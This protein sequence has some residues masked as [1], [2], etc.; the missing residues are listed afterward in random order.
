ML[1]INTDVFL[2]NSL[3]VCDSD[4]WDVVVVT[5]GL[6]I[7]I[8]VGEHDSTI[9]EARLAV[10]L[11]LVARFQVPPF[12]ELNILAVD[13]DQFGLRILRSTQLKGSI[14]ISVHLRVGRI[15]RFIN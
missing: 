5:E 3:E 4:I 8:N 2:T 7:L 13:L 9:F 12:L 11:E 6:A 1:P 10:K 15:S 14:F